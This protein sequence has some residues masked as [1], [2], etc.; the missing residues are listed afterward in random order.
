[1]LIIAILMQD[2]RTRCIV[3]FNPQFGGLP[4]FDN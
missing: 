2:S 1:M 3:E 4:Y